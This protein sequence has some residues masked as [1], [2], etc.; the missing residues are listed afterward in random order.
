[1][2]C[3]SKEA[4]AGSMGAGSRAT[5]LCSMNER[6]RCGLVIVMSWKEADVGHPCSSYTQSCL[7]CPLGTLYVFMISV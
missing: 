5:G 6:L 7:S 1:M 2:E 3:D 4:D